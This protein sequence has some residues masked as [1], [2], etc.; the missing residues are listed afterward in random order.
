[1][2]GMLKHLPSICIIFSITLSFSL[3]LPQATVSEYTIY[4]RMTEIV[5]P[6]EL[7]YR[8]NYPKWTF[9]EFEYTFEIINPSGR[10]LYIY[11]STTCLVFVTGNLSFENEQYFG[12]VRGG[13]SLCGDAFTNHTIN[14]G[15]TEG[16]L[17]FTFS[18]NDTLEAL[19]NGNYTVWIFLAEYEEQHN[20]HHFTSE[21]AVNGSD[22]Q[23]TH[24]GANTTFTFPE[25]EPNTD[26]NNEDNERQ[27]FTISYSYTYLIVLLLVSSYLAF[28]KKRRKSL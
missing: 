9:F 25:E 22:I 6:P 15:I 17:T 18:V 23:I 13:P 5:L 3:F 14:P 7:I 8:E 21:I 10:I 24:N 1:M 26:T 19:P 27:T 20:Y 28:R 11:T 2:N 12:Q 4:T 16:I